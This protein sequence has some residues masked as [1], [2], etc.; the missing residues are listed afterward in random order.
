MRQIARLL[1]GGTLEGDRSAAALRDQRARLADVRRL[2]YSVND[3]LTSDEEVG[4][5]AP[6]RDH[7]EE[8]VA[9][10]LLSA[11][12][13]R[14]PPERIERFGPEVAAAAGEVSARLGANG[15]GRTR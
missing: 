5:A 13:F 6:V 14:V 11:P 8:P 7:R 10:V 2:G 15:A 9:A 4:I 12:R 3:G 1:D